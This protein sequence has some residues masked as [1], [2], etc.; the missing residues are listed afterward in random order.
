MEIKHPLL[1]EQVVTSLEKEGIC[2][3]SKE[4]DLVVETYLQQTAK[5]CL[6][7]LLE[8]RKKS[9]VFRTSKKYINHNVGTFYI[10]FDRGDGGKN[11]LGEIEKEYYPKFK[12]KFSD[13][14]YKELNF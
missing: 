1:L 10:H 2:L 4:L 14:F 7:N 9:E 6:S 5:N 11:S 8:R 13:N 3:T 12:V